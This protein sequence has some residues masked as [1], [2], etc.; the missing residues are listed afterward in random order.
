MGKK[1]P[2]F[3]KNYISFFSGQCPQCATMS[4]IYNTFLGS[5]GVAHWVHPVYMIFNKPILPTIQFACAE[6]L[7]ISAEIHRTLEST[8]NSMAQILLF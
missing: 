3:T 1:K 8:Y 5:L 4:P 7:K 6:K 2:I